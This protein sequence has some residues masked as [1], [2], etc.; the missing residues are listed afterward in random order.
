MA[1]ILEPIVVWVVLVVGLAVLSWPTNWTCRILLIALAAVI[2][3]LLMRRPA[4]RAFSREG[5]IRDLGLAVLC[6][7]ILIPA[8]ILI[9]RSIPGLQWHQ[10]NR[11]TWAIVGLLPQMAV[12]AVVEEL[13][14]RG[15]IQNRLATGMTWPR[16]L[17]RA[18]PILVV[19]VL[20][21]AAHVLVQASWMASMTFLPGL[22]LG[23]LY[24]QTGRLFAP[25]VFHLMAN[26][27]WL[28]AF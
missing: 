4:P 12:I 25:I 27:F 13:F 5:F 26:I 2:P 16:P 20:F 18:G 28:V 24:A 8:A 15:Y 14:F 22:V 21:A 11:S 1:A 19:S 23:W 3:D 6:C 17:A 7:L 9:A 10:T